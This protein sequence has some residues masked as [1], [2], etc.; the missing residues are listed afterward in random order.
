MIVYAIR[1][2][3][4]SL[5]YKNLLKSADR[6]MWVIIQQGIEQEKKLMIL[7]HVDYEFFCPSF[8]I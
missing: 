8:L 5:M 7:A 2:S 3:F 1:K 6:F 4:F